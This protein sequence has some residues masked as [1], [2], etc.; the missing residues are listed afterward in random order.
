M[1]NPETVS[2]AVLNSLTSDSFQ[3]FVPQIAGLSVPF[4]DWFSAIIDSIIERQFR[5]NLS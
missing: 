5:K 4:K 2:K 1:L 3:I